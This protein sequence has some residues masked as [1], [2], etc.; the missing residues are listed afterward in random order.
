MKAGSGKASLSSVSF[1][2]ARGKRFWVL[3]ILL[4]GVLA[5]VS[6]EVSHRLHLGELAAKNGV[7]L[8]GEVVNLTP[9]V[10]EGRGMVDYTFVEREEDFLCFSEP[11]L[12]WL[13]G[14]RLPE[15]NC[16]PSRK[17]TLPLRAFKSKQSIYIKWRVYS[18]YLETPKG[19][20]LFIDGP[21]LFDEKG[22][23]YF[24]LTDVREAMK[25][26]CLQSLEG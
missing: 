25:R 12:D 8:S 18:S 17:R 4:V 24:T 13:Y 23:L 20:R 7:S 6:L 14:G 15:P 3:S 2:R 21:V 11:R 22:Y 5:L 16:F 26:S 10:N 19:D 9:Y 1:I